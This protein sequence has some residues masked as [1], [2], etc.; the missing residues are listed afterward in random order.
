M[1]RCMQLGHGD[2]VLKRAGHIKHK[3]A[4][5]WLKG[6]KLKYEVTS[7]NLLINFECLYDLNANFATVWEHT[8]F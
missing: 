3:R 2:S 6:L 7:I 4:F 8:I 1:T 5:D